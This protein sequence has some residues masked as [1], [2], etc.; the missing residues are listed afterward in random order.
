MPMSKPWLIRILLGGFLFPLLAHAQPGQLRFD[1]FDGSNLTGGTIMMLQDSIGYFWMGTQ[2]GLVKWDGSEAQRYLHRDG[3]S[4]TLANSEIYSLAID[5]EQNLWI[6]TLSGLSFFDRRTE[7]FHNLLPGVR[8]VDLQIDQSG[9]LW[10]GTRK[11][12]LI[13]IAKDS[14]KVTQFKH[15]PETPG[16]IP[17]NR[18]GDLVLADNGDLW[19]A[20]YQ[21]GISII[22]LSEMD[23]AN[24]DTLIDLKTDFIAFDPENKD[25]LPSGKFRDMIQAR[26][27]TWWI[28]ASKGGVTHYDPTQDS[29]EHFMPDPDDPNS[30]TSTEGYSLMEAQDGKI[31]IGTWAGGLNILDPVT[32]KIQ[33]YQHQPDL[34]NSLPDDVIIDLFQ[35]AEGLIWISTFYGGLAIHDPNWNAFTVYRNNPTDPNTITQNFIRGVF[36][37]SDN[38]LWIGTNNKGLNVFYRDEGR[39]ELFEHDPNDPHSIASNSPWGGLKDQKGK[40]W[41]GCNGGISRFRPETRDWVSFTHDPNDPHTL[42]N[43]T[44]L[45][46]GEAPD[47]Y[48]W[49]GTWAYGLNVVDPET[50][51]VTRFEFSEEPGGLPDCGIKSLLFD[52]QGRLWLGTTEGL[53]LYQA[54]DSTF[55]PYIHEPN[56]PESISNNSINDLK[57]DPE[58][59]IVCC[60][61]GGLSI[62]N[63]ET[64]VFRNFRYEQGLR[65]EMITGMEIAPDGIFWLATGEGIHRFDPKTE[66]LSI[67]SKEDGIPDDG[68]APWANHI[69]NSGRIYMGTSSGLCEFRPE[70]LVEYS[71]PS[72]TA[73]TGFFLFNRPVPIHPDSALPMALPFLDGITLDHSDDI[74]AF[75]FS[76]LSNRKNDKFEYAYRLNGFNDNWIYTDQLNRRA[77]FTNVPHGTYTFEV[78]SRNGNGIWDEV[79]DSIIVR[80]LP[81]WWKT[82][83]ARSLGILIVI[84]IAFAIYWSRV[85]TLNRQ[86]KLL[87]IKVRE[88]T[89]EVVFQNNLLSQQK[90]EIE[91]EKDRSDELLLNILPEAVADELKKDQQSTPRYFPEVSILFSDFVGFTQLSEGMTPQ[92]LVEILHTIFKEFDRI[93]GEHNLEKIKTIGDAYMV[94]GG[95][96]NEPQGQA[97]AVVAAGLDMIKAVEKFNETQKAK[98]LPEWKVR[99]GI[100]TGE[101]VAGVVGERK[102]QFDIWGD[103]VNIASRMESSG[104][105]NRVNISHTTYERIKDTYHCTFR[106]K[107]PAKNK[108]EIEMFLVEG[109]KAP[110]K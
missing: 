34:S 79:G 39:F 53:L 90:E 86:K 61:H 38:E 44:I 11:N 107:I 21:T 77:T 46:L 14:R 82:W 63:P 89:A 70:D 51:Y 35:D 16:P 95:L 33:Q 4:T 67:Y 97:T 78:R 49:A 59:N 85:S 5:E 47:G 40:I 10:C 96:H 27:G 22:K 28:A 71:E 17:G 99:L 26:D 102:F 1:I 73:I 93:V 83:W 58:G 8:V 2:E 52:S 36:E 41:M 104:Q 75:S 106:G 87:E 108:G 32:K 6:G 84:G 105:E 20:V 62:L 45:S 60:T 56:N 43:N 54:A 23:Q 15:A 80:I 72:P 13:R 65:S 94:A 19:A 92:H 9:N 74:F 7:K 3:D 91:K 69:G 110:V 48:L 81:P 100:N 55:K 66:A 25:R 31:W 98:G 18:V 29:W 30:M 50:G 64:E 101:V 88:A 57:E 42:S 37:Y 76:S 24:V 103:A 109:P 12:G 68:F